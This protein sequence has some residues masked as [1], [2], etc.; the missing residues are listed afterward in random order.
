MYIILQ[1]NSTICSPALFFFLKKLLSG[2]E[3]ARL[4]VFVVLHSVPKLLLSITAI[5][6]Q[7]NGRLFETASL[8]TLKYSS[9]DF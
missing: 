9:I 4:Q 7:E 5:D 1:S 6:K 3:I 8:P 2:C